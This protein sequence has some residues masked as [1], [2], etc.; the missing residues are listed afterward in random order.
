MHHR[1]F[2]LDAFFRMHI[3]GKMDTELS[4]QA[5]TPDTST[6]KH[7]NYGTCNINYEAHLRVRVQG[8]VSYRSINTAKPQKI[9]YGHGS[10]RL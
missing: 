2:M 8:P 6:M 7:T 9:G 10:I 4:L 3:K 5:K 1:S